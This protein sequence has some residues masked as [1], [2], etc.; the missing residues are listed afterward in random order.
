M[1]KFFKLPCSH[2]FTLM[3][4]YQYTYT[5]TQDSLHIHVYPYTY[6]YT[7]THAKKIYPKGKTIRNHI[8]AT[9]TF[10]GSP[11]D[12]WYW[13]PLLAVVLSIFLLAWAVMRLFQ[14]KPVYV[15]GTFVYVILCARH[16]LVM[17][18]SCI[19]IT[20]DM[21][22]S[23]E[24]TGQTKHLYV[25]ACASSRLKHV[26]SNFVIIHVPQ[27]H[28]THTCWG[29]FH[30]HYNFKVTFRHWT[31]QTVFIYAEE[32]VIRIIIPRS[33]LG[34]QRVKKISYM[35][36]KNSII[37]GSHL[38]RGTCETRTWSD[39]SSL[40]LRFSSISACPDLA[41]ALSITAA[42]RIACSSIR[43]SGSS[44]V[45]LLT[46]GASSMH[47][48]CHTSACCRVYWCIW[49]MY[50]YVYVYAYRHIFIYIYI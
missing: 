21:R 31:C 1:S 50:V 18:A 2:V 45:S 20:S 10:I 32:D 4:S 27:T 33:R 37:P 15:A 6:T 3:I 25:H 41:L 44:S 16:I 36:K 29:K 9:H 43:I 23:S 28:R 24:G 7:H 42:S 14:P 48:I 35:L 11:Q 17:Y 46:L 49:Y 38:R 26:C 19:I 34:V 8:A 22:F 12:L 30:T 47:R 5:W 40:C 39:T 13:V